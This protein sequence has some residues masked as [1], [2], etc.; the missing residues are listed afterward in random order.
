MENLSDV[1]STHEQRV[2][3]ELLPKILEDLDDSSKVINA[4]SYGELITLFE[5]FTKSLAATV[6]QYDDQDIDFN[7]LY[8]FWLNECISKVVLERTIVPASY[9]D[10]LNQFCSDILAN[11][12]QSLVTHYDSVTRIQVELSSKIKEVLLK[13]LLEIEFV[14]LQVYGSSGS[15]LCLAGTSDID[16]VLCVN[17]RRTGQG[18]V[19]IAVTQ[20]VFYAIAAAVGQA[21]YEVNEVVLNARVP[22]L[23]LSHKELQIEVCSFLIVIVSLMMCCNSMRCTLFRLICA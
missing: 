3:N 20:K 8:T 23:K 19:T 2:L 10:L 22:V 5:G 12:A 7:A 11:N 16:L 9:I 1:V 21:G 15:N 18:E 6:T 4:L 13:E 17:H 14:S